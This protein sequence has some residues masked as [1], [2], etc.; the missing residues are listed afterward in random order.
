MIVFCLLWFNQFS[1]FLE[2]LWDLFS[3]DFSKLHPLETIMLLKYIFSSFF[4]KN[5]LYFEQIGKIIGKQSRKMAYK[6]NLSQKNANQYG[7]QFN[8]LV[9][10]NQMNLLFLFLLKHVK[11]MFLI[12]IALIIEIL[13][14][15]VLFYFNNIGFVIR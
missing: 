2:E 3:V 6:S 8:R 12:I 15:Y 7:V 14:L 5:R 9:T 1:L 13:I 11:M 10:L 4:F